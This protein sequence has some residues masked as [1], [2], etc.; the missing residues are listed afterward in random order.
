MILYYRIEFIQG[1]GKGV[2]GVETE[3]GRERERDSRRLEACHEHVE[4]EARR[5]GRDGSRSKEKQ[6][7]RAR[8][9]KKDREEG[10]SRPFYSELGTPG[11]C[12]VIVG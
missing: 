7:N 9:R 6:G 11:C 4:K 8:A 2:E 1:M 12:Q 10:A 5:M 3:K